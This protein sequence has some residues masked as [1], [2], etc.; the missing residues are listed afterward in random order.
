MSRAGAALLVLAAGCGGGPEAAPQPPATWLGEPISA[1]QTSAI[2]AGTGHAGPEIENPYTGDEGA[3]AQGRQLFEGFNCA[4]CHG[5][6][7]GGGMGPPLAD[8]DWIYGSSDAQIYASIVQGRPNGMPSFGQSLTG[9]AVWKLAAYVKSLGP[10]TGENQG[11]G[12][13]AA[14]SEGGGKQA[15]GRQSD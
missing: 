15:G 8:K 13:Q 12:S 2:T 6:A 3:R 4:G 14:K 7:G 10:G 9:E 11:G 5:S 1:V